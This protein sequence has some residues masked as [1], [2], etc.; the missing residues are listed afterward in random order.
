MWRFFCKILVIVTLFVG[1][2]A[3]LHASLLARFPRANVI[4]GTLGTV[5]LNLKPHPKGS[6]ADTVD[7][8]Y[9][10]V[11][12][13]DTYYSSSRENYAHIH[14]KIRMHDGQETKYYERFLDFNHQGDALKITEDVIACNHNPPVFQPLH[15]EEPKVTA[16]EAKQEL[17]DRMVMTD[18]LLNLSIYYPDHTFLDLCLRGGTCNIEGVSGHMNLDIAGIAQCVIKNPKAKISEFGMFPIFKSRGH[19]RIEIIGIEGD[20]V[21]VTA[22]DDS[23]IKISNGNLYRADLEALG[24]SNVS[25]RDVDIRDTLTAT[26]HQKSNIDVTGLVKRAVTSTPDRGS[27]SIHHKKDVLSVLPRA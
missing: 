24:Q 23:R 11:Q 10:I 20:S 25:L 15:R 1:S 26:A 22:K 6:D 12:R 13:P 27:V 9:H 3:S 19:G 2:G 8:H 5:N 17:I 18:G 4:A 14:Q 7:V 16:A 21:H